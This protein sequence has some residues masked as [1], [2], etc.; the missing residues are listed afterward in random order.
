MEETGKPN[1]IT[2]I[3]VLCFNLINLIFLSQNIS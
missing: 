2:M 1:Q 3:L